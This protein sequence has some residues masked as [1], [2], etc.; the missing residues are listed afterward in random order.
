MKKL[1]TMIR[2]FQKKISKFSFYSFFKNHNKHVTVDLKTKI[3]QTK[4]AVT[5]I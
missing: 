4:I 3:Q 1:K 5:K 2:D